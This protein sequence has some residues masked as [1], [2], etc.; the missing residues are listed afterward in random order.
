M[1]Q[2]K[3]NFR[4]TLRLFFSSDKRTQ[5]IISQENSEREEI[6]NYYYFSFLFQMELEQE[7]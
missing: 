2:Y 5:R 7:I 4:D 6:V 3:T 1:G